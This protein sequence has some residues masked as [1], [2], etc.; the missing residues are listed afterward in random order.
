M[1]AKLRRNLLF[2]LYPVKGSLWPWHLDQLNR[3]WRQFN[4][5]KII[6]VSTDKKTDDLRAVKRRLSSADAEFVAV[7]NDSHLGETKHFV[8]GLEMLESVRENELT[9]YAHGKSVTHSGKQGLIIQSWCEAMYHLNLS[10]PN[11]IGRLM[12]HRDAVGCFRQKIRH[13]GSG[14]HFPGT[15][16]WF[17]HAAL[18]KR[19]WRTISRGRYGV[20]GYLGRHIPIE[21]SGSL[22]PHRDYWELYNRALSLKECR[23][24]LKEQ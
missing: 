3:H 17:K 16:F 5:R 4:G 24:W 7:R 2:Y 13:G 18:F 21:K 22:T 15:F 12:A 11:L 20:E 23:R 6:I 14:W 19:N 10:S 1:P 9:F 8:K